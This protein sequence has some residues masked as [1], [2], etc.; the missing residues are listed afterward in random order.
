MGYNVIPVIFGFI[1][2]YT[3]EKVTI[4]SRRLRASES[5]GLSAFLVF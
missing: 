4:L 3:L 5:V 2:V 1:S